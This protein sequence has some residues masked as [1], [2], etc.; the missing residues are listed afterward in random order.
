MANDDLDR[1]IAKTRTTLEH[2]RTLRVHLQRGIEN[3]SGDSKKHVEAMLTLNT[4][5]I[6]SLEATLAIMRKRKA[7]APVKTLR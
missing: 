1:G 7:S 3:V 4:K 6:A 2:F 5:T